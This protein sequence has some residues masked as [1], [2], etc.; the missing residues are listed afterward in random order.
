MFS[1]TKH[2]LLSLLSTGHLFLHQ[3]IRETLLSPWR[4]STVFSS[5]ILQLTKLQTFNQYQGCNIANK[6]PF[7]QGLQYKLS[8]L[9]VNKLFTYAV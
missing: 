1:T 6:A 4:A 5:C 3:V 9:N 8:L 7:I 2:H